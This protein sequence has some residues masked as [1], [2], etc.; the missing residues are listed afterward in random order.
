[1]QK[2]TLATVQTVEL[3]ITNCPTSLIIPPTTNNELPK[4]LLLSVIMIVDQTSITTH[5]TDES[6]D[7]TSSLR[8]RS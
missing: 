7:Y 2:K 5:V 6:T 8:M 1:M 4:T 3:A